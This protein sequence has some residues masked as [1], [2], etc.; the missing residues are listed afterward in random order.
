M[1]RWMLAATLAA[2]ALGMSRP[3]LAIT[4]EEVFRTFR[5]NFVNPGGRAT[6]MGGAFIG[7]ADDATAAA[8]NPAGLTNL[9]AAELFTELRLEDTEPTIIVGNVRDPRGGAAPVVTR[10]SGEPDNMLFPS[11]IS[12]VKPFEHWTF[13]ISR[14]EVLNTQLQASNL[15]TDEPKVPAPAAAR[16]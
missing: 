8:A 16:G 15:F 6:G 4:D 13:G 11:F 12:F 3:A 9:I 5:F 1:K 2:A 14:Q 10:S 7:I